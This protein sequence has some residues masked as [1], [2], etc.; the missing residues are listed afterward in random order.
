MVKNLLVN[1]RDIRDLGSIPG[2]E[3][4]SEGE[5]ANPLQ[6]SCLENPGMEEAGGLQYMG[7]QK[8]RTQLKQLST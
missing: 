8:S 6:Y 5:N 7:S 2:W 4:S 3:R 1:A